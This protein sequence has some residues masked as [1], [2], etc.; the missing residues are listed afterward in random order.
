MHG[1]QHLFVLMRARDGQNIRMRAGDILG[2]GPQTA[3]H[4]HPSV[5]AQRL[6]DRLKAFG[7]GGIEEPA[8][9]HDDRIRAGIVGRDRIALG[10]QARQDAFAIDQGLGT[11]K[12]HHPDCRLTL[13][14]TLIKTG[15][16]GKVGAQ[17]W[18]V[19]AHLAHIDA[20]LWAE[21]RARL[22][23]PDRLRA[24]LSGGGHRVWKSGAS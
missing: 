13:A 16:G 2:L 6:A 8:G 4:D 23:G 10:A 3:G 22:R 14:G 12:G 17:V 18:R 24:N 9:V 5:F 19:R 11:A 7:F 20:N 1:V 15:F 21:K